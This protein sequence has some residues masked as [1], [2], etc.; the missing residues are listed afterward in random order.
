MFSN[1]VPFPVVSVLSGFFELDVALPDWRCGTGV[2][3]G[4]RVLNVGLGEAEPDLLIED[5]VVVELDAGILVVDASPD[6]V[7]LSCTSTGTIITSV[8]PSSFVVV[9]VIV[10]AN[11]GSVSVSVSVTI[12]CSCDVTDFVGRA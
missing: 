4:G 11:T 7:V 3:V 6:I 8:S 1:G 9:C 5:E 12:P 2:V 10:E